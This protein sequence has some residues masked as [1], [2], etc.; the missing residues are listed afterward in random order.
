VILIAYDGSDDAKAAIEQAGKLFPGEPTT[1]LNVW[2][3]F[4]DTMARVGG[5]LGVIVDYDQIDKDTEQAAGEKAD[6]GVALAREAGLDASA[7]IE[8]VE[9]TVADAI[10]GAAATLAV[11]VVV[12]GSRGFTGVRSLMLGSVSHA[13][14]QHADVPVLVVPS[15]AVAQ[16][17]SEHRQSLG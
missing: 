17:R 6:E 10:L 11:R 2:H 15:P 16:A 14:L 1:V 12:C 9:T 3:R 8:M 5:G 4:I 7:R 13:L